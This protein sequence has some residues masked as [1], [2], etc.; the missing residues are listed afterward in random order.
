MYCAQLA[1][2][3]LWPVFFFVLKWWL[4]SFFWIA[5]LAVLVIV[6]TVRFYR[7]DETAGLLQ[8]PYTVW[9]LFASYLN[10]AAYILNG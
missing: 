8:I 1:V 6:M 2:N 7:R 10:L 5:A 9:V 4:F 3:L